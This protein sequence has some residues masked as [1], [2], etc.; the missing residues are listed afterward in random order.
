M[1]AYHVYQN[2]AML[3][4]A[5]QAWDYGRALTISDVNVATGSIP[6]KSFNFTKTCS[7]STLVGGTFWQTKVND[8][9]IY[10][11]STAVFFT[12]S[13]YLYQATSNNTYL[14]AAQDSGAFLI[15][16]MHITG[17][18]NGIAA[19]SVNDSA[20]CD[21]VFGAGASQIAHA[22][23][24]FMEGLALLPSDTSFGQQNLSVETLRS[25]LVNITLTTNFFVNAANGTINT[26]GGLLD[27]TSLVQG[28][29]SLYHTISGPANLITYH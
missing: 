16:I 1:R 26:E 10:G 19:M 17:V 20:S 9:T 24:S 3:D 11:I 21:D 4:V 5:T 14:D 2:P 15:D 28:L 29:G 27:Q 18:N 7:G 8:A 22:G 25:N 6:S 23:F 12:L 13:A